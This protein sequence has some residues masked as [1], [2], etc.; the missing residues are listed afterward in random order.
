MEVHAAISLGLDFS[1]GKALAAQVWRT[2][3]SRVHPT[4]DSGHFIMVVSFGRSSFRLD[5]DSVSLALEAYTG[6]YCDDLN[7]SILRDFLCFF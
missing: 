2:L 6:G 1:P 7:V 3:R 5:D 4:R